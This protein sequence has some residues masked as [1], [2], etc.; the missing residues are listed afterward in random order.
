MQTLKK[1]TFHVNGPQLFNFL[2]ATVRNMTSCGVDEFKQK[3]ETFLEKLPDEPIV[4]C[5]VPGAWTSV[6]AACNSSPDHGGE[7]CE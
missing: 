4:Q 3:L 1:Q 6:V 2:L 5:L 7:S